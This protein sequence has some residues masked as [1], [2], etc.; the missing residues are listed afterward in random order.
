MKIKYKGVEYEAKLN[1]KGHVVSIDG[2][3]FFGVSLEKLIN[4]E[5]VEEQIESQA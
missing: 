5:V 1:D 3:L 4:A 2:R